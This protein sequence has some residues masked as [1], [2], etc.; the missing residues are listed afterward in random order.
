METLEK[1]GTVVG[2]GSFLPKNSKSVCGRKSEN[3]FA[4]S[5]M[6]PFGVPMFKNCAAGFRPCVFQYSFQAKSDWK[7]VF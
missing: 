3:S 4:R 6:L 7:T 2:T 1:S 5:P